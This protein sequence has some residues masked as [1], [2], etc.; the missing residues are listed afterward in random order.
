MGYQADEKLPDANPCAE[1]MS[2]RRSADAHTTCST[3]GR[4]RAPSRTLDPSQEVPVPPG[5]ATR[6]AD[7]IAGR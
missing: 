3:G 1:A 6:T 4:I 7:F 2:D 5:A